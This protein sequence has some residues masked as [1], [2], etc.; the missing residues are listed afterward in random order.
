[1]LYCR[2]IKK[3]RQTSRETR[4]GVSPMYSDG[5]TQSSAPQGTVPLRAGL[6]GIPIRHK[7]GI[8]DWHRRNIHA[9]NRGFCID[10]EE[11][12][13]DYESMRPGEFLQTPPRGSGRLGRSGAPEI[14]M[15]LKRILFSLDASTGKSEYRYRSRL[16]AVLRTSRS[17][18]FKCEFL[19]EKV[20][21]M[22]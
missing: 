20:S 19:Y 13:T 22:M 6:L 14:K 21:P 12:L 3:E 8:A 9:E 18:G 7:R 10:R 1:M 16:S 11:I 2:H 5:D 17:S 4:K 15:L